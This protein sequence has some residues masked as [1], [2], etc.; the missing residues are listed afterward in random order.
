[1]SRI[2]GKDTAPEIL[3]RKHLH[4]AGYRFRLHVPDLPGRPDIVLKKH[5]TVIFVHGCFWHRHRNCPN[6][7]VPRTNVAFWSDKFHKTVERDRAKRAELEKA[8]W[9]VI[10]VWECQL[11]KDLRKT[12]KLVQDKLTV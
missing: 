3:L 10:T 2:R 1:M 6:T 8:G 7:T 4:K 12:M 11:K 9:Q 5:K